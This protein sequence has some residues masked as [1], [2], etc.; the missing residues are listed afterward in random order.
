[1]HPYFPHL[2]RD[3]QEASERREPKLPRKDEDKLPPGV[4]AWLAG[5]PLNT[6]SEQFGMVKKDF[7][8]ANVWSADELGQLVS[9]LEQLWQ[10]FHLIP[11]F[12]RNLPLA[13]QYELMVAALDRETPVMEFGFFHVEFC[14]YNPENC[15]FEPKQC[16]C[17]HAFEPEKGPL[18]TSDPQSATR[19]SQ[20]QASRRLEQ[21]IDKMEHSIITRI[22][23][24][25]LLWSFVNP[26]KKQSL[27]A[28]FG[29]D[30]K[31]LPPIQDLSLMDR[32]RMV[33]VII[34]LWAAFGIFPS[35]PENIPIE[36]QYETL[37][38]FW[39]HKVRQTSAKKQPF[40]F[41]KGRPE[42]CPFGNEYCNCQSNQD[43]KGFRAA[44]K[45]DEI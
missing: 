18:V 10:K 8:A 37:V 19:K 21:L 45:N 30:R 2:L 42:A 24:E 7:P 40:T 43:S 41:C 6:L 23:G 16:N 32:Q 4:E 35:F 38:R 5:E 27:G 15:P 28:W 1:M 29:I 25:D 12:P 26:L 31:E 22:A 14:D 20:P 36:L 13:R 3:I 34:R 44:D 39:D 17:R 9:A 11:E 33:K